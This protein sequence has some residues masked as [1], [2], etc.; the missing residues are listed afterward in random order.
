MGPGVT[1]THMKLT[2]VLTC[3]FFM[4]CLFDVQHKRCVLTLLNRILEALGSPSASCDTYCTVFPGTEVLLTATEAR[5]IWIEKKIIS[6]MRRK[7]PWFF[8]FI[9][10]CFNCFEKGLPSW[11][12]CVF[13]ELQFFKGS[14][15]CWSCSE[16]W[17]PKLN[18][19]YGTP[20]TSFLGQIMFFW[21]S[22]FFRESSDVLVL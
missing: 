18:W 10:I 4:H 2:A 3:P 19:E 7:S 13:W 12:K 14:L 9:L 20:N 5:E 1:H 6:T 16:W 11:T 15:A 8:I 17:G 22:Q 21:E